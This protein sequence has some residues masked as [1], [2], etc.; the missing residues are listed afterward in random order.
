LRYRE[1]K[2]IIVVIARGVPDI[3]VAVA[4]RVVREFTNNIGRELF[5]LD[6]ELQMAADHRR[7]NCLLERRNSLLKERRCRNRELEAW[8]LFGPKQ[9]KRIGETKRITRRIMKIGASSR[10]AASGRQ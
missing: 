5:F 10:G 8:Q 6:N 9:A 1:I 2:G 3:L 4:G 7:R